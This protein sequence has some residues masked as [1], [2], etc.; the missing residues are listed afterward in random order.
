MELDLE[1]Q[2][3]HGKDDAF[4]TEDFAHET[5]KAGLG[6]VKEKVQDILQDVRRFKAC[7]NSLV[8][9]S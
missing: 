8:H 5:I 7:L 3:R 1:R 9:F 2:R 6:F 4:T